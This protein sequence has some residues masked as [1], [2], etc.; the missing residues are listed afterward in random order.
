MISQAEAI[1][2]S[3][4]Y[5]SGFSPYVIPYQ[6]RAHDLIRKDFNYAE[7]TLEILLS[8]SYGSAKSI[9][10]AHIA[11][12]HCLLYPGARACLARK[13][14]PDLKDTIF[15]EI[16]EHLEG[17]DTEIDDEPMLIEG[18]DYWVNNSRAMITFKNG[19][20][21]ISRSWADKKYNKGRSLKLSM[22]ILEELTENNEEDMAAFK[23]LKARLRR[24][25]HV[26]ENVLLAATNPDS[27]SHWVYRYFIGDK[28]PFK[29]VFYSITTDNPYLDSVYIEQLKKTLP[30]KEAD[31]YLRGQ[32]VDIASEAIYYSYD[33]DKQYLYQD[34]QVTSE[35]IAISFDFN[36]GH[37]K[38]LSC[39]IGQY[40]FQKDTYNCFDEATIEGLRTLQMLEEIAGRGLFER[41]NVFQIFGDATGK[42][43]STTSI[44]SNYEQI[45]TFLANYRRKDGSQLVYEMHVPQ[46]NPPISKRHILVNSYCLN[47]L[48][49]TRLF[50]WAGT[51]KN[52]TTNAYKC[53]VL[54]QGLRQTKFKKNSKIEDDNNAFQ[55]VTTALGY[56]IN[57]QIISVNY[58][59]NL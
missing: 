2:L 34:Y 18:E 59:R 52:E 27:P 11:V 45:E 33:R 47:D 12:T 21:I 57:S 44:H 7:A 19:S 43:R 38:P 22:L 35:P 46:S 41:P 36:I 31:R 55:H 32:W 15:K 8:G 56:W 28:E 14:M 37:G 16:I 26:P 13:S 6:G 54:D 42:A 40:D 53:D 51:Q 29:R 23:T 17:Y 3:K 30:L 24:L 39:T 58:Y 4:P 25:P 1:K 48:K 10:M 49:Q 9:F 5:L 50:L 20:E